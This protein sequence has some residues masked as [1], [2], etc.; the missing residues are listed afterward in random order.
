[1]TQLSNVNEW[2]QYVTGLHSQYFPEIFVPIKSRSQKPFKKSLFLQERT[3]GYSS[4]KV[5]FSYYS[6]LV[7]CIAIPE[8]LR[9]FIEVKIKNG[10]FSAR[11]TQNNLS[12][13]CKKSNVE[14][15]LLNDQ[16]NNYDMDPY[17]HFDLQLHQEWSLRYKWENPA[18]IPQWDWILNLH[19][20]WEGWQCEDV[21]DLLWQ[22]TLQW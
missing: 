21:D 8:I 22:Q 3:S 5:H 10:H 18:L 9:P 2:K 1:M 15:P 17:L 11:K 6:W 7:N 20:F 13:T 14:S 4:K 12:C 19:Q 16:L